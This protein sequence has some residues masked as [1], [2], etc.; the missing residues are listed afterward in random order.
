MSQPQQ[1]ASSEAPNAAAHR[2]FYDAYAQDSENKEQA[3]SKGFQG[4]RP[5][6]AERRSDLLQYIRDNIIGKDEAIDTPF[7]VRQITYADYT[8]SGRSLSFIED[9][10]RNEVLPLY[11][12]T[13]T[14]TSTCGLQTTMFRNEAREIVKRNVRGGKDDVVFFTGSG[15]TG[16]VCLLM[17][18]LSLKERAAKNPDDKPVVFVGPY[19]HHSNLLPWRETG[20]EIVTIKEGANGGV[21]LADLES[22]L[23]RYESR[24]LKIGSFSAASNISGILTDTLA[25]TALMR[26]YGCLSFWDYAAAAPYTEID[27]NPS[28]DQSLAKDAIFL[29]PHKFV[30][31]PGTPGVLVVKKS[32]LM[33]FVPSAPGGGTVFFVGPHS[34]RYLQN[35][36]E[37]EEGGTPDIIGAIRAGLVFQL[38]EAVGVPLIHQ[39]EQHLL[40]M[41]MEAFKQQP[42]LVV[43]GNPNAARLPILSF[44]IKF[45][46]SELFLH[47]NFVSVLLNDLFGIQSRAGCLCAG[48]YAQNELGMDLAKSNAYESSLLEKNELVRPG[49]VRLNL[50]YF[51]SDAEAQFLIQ[52]VLF[53]A[54]HGYKLLP[55][56]GFYVDSG[57]WKHRTRMT[58]FVGRRW[59]SRISYAEGRMG[60]R[61]EHRTAP[62]SP[63]QYLT[64]AHEAVDKAMKGYSSYGLVDQAQFLPPSAQSLRW[65]ALPSEALSLI[66]GEKDVV[67]SLS[68]ASQPLKVKNVLV[69]SVE[70]EEEVEEEEVKEEVVVEQKTEVSAASAAASVSAESSPTPT[71]ST[72]ASTPAS[73]IR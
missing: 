25:P 36:E 50:N 20:A 57:E 28:N 17:Y 67:K 13:H 26:R 62:A 35:F 44:M 30:G 69:L 70:G 64:M 66:K 23:K 21:D 41:A 9:Y 51:I 10:I 14:L 38:K 2:N 72:L 5:Q 54:Q 42:N 58:R 6:A 3:P 40:S 73:T 16:G 1:S 24:L 55:Q 11:A 45:P 49:F 71:S 52:S 29:S 15:A 22:A 48:P 7:G 37:R 32:L 34:H 53:V 59:L 27:M 12:N 47:S 19:E 61:S 4:S 46:G 43:L 39:R 65:F 68:Q 63:E 8:A 33:N 31:G 56:Y 60:Y 18:I